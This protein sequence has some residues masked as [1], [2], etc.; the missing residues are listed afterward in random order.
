MLA[1]SWLVVVV[2]V[3]GSEGGGC[4]VGGGGGGDYALDAWGTHLI[5]DGCR[6]FGQRQT[7]HGGQLY[8]GQRVGV[9]GPHVVHGQEH[10]HNVRRLEGTA[11]RG[12]TKGR[13]YQHSGRQREKAENRGIRRD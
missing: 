3:G 8:G 12:V 9:R 10:L 11:Q 7:V 6:W 4:V 5:Q 13:V 1:T 2:V